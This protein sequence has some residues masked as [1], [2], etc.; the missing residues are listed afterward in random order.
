MS[1]DYALFIIIVS[2][3]FDLANSVVPTSVSADATRRE[4][5]T[6]SVSI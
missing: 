6:V 4:S 1:N 3:D 2:N 5:T